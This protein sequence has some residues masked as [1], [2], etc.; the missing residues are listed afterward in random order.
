M[1]TI[2]LGV[3]SGKFDN[4]VFEYIPVLGNLVFLNHTIS[5]ISFL[6]GDEE[7]AFK[8]PF[9]KQGIVGIAHVDSKYGALGKFE[10]PCNIDFM[11]IA[12]SHCGKC[13]K[14]AVM[15]QKQMELYRTLG[16]PER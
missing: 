12:F 15:I 5:R 6:S 10:F 9:C 2:L 14:I 4:L 11:D 16:L 7:D 8:N 3:I 13:W 1:G